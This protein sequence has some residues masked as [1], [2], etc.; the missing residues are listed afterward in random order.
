MARPKIK[1]NPEDVKKLASIGCTIS[2]M[3]SF[4]ECSRDTIERRFAAEVLKGRDGGKTRLRRLMWQSA[5]KGNAVM[6]IFLAKNV[7]GYSD[8]VDQTMQAEVKVSDG[9]KF[10]F[11]EPKE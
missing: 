7:L 5:E 2:E 11:L 10:K 8:K 4:F 9:H 6:Q 1:I 3:A